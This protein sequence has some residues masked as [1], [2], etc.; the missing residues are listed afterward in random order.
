[1]LLC[2]YVSMFQCFNVSES[3]RVRGRAIDR[4]RCLAV[5]ALPLEAYELKRGILTLSKY[6]EGTSENKRAV[7]VRAC[8]RW[9]QG[10]A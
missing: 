10:V 1:M 9:I 4:A 6:A 8:S 3:V 5:P 2:F 7:Y